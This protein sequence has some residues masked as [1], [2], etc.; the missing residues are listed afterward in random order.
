MS[1]GDADERVAAPAGAEGRDNLSRDLST[2]VERVGWFAL[3]CI[4]TGMAI[5]ASVVAAILFG[6]LLGLDLQDLLATMAILLVV[7][8]VV[9]MPGLA[10]T[11]R[12]VQHLV[13]GQLRLEDEIRQRA[14]AEMRLRELAAK[15]DLTGL[16]NRRSFVDSGQKLAALCHRHDRWLALLVLDLDGFKEANDRRGHQA[17]DRLLQRLARVLQAEIRQSDIAARLGGDE[18]AVMLPDSDLGQAALVAERIREAIAGR[19]QSRRPDGEHRGRRQPWRA[20]RSR[21]SSRPRRSGPL[22][23][24]APGAEPGGRRDGRAGGP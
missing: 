12:L 20:R 15:D 8:L 16:A 4:G 17:G 24:Q 19:S 14:Q 13:R 6:P 21:R 10:V 1:V 3:A 22:R 23:G 2:A 7:S 5:I 9:V 18:F 11:L